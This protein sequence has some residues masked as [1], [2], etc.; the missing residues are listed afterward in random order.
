MTLGWHKDDDHPDLG[1]THFQR[2]T[3]EETIHDPGHIEVEAPLGFLEI[4][5]DRLPEELHE[6]TE[7]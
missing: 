1:T 6:T 2:E 4:C 3:G 5:L 7:C